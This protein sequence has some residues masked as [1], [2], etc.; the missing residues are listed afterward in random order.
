MEV[1]T[2]G[3]LVHEGFPGRV[4]LF[5]GGFRCGKKVLRFRCLERG[6]FGQIKKNGA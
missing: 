2:D 5:E 3:V 4:H 1:D 6:G